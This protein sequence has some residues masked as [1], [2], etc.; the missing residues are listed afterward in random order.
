[1]LDP[2]AAGSTLLGYNG[3]QS[4]FRD[5]SASAEESGRDRGE[6]LVKTPQ[7]TDR[8]ART[9]MNVVICRAFLQAVLYPAI[10]RRR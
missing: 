5:V 4:S 6:V 9:A 2:K 10:G 8:I 1:M 7:N 3:V